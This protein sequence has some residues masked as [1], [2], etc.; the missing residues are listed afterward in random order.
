MS[1]CLLAAHLQ[2][3]VKFFALFFI[4]FLSLLGYHDNQLS[5]PHIVPGLLNYYMHISLTFNIG[6]FHALRRN[7]IV[8]KKI[9]D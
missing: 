5:N 1:F 3:V 7:Y 6:F 2:S 8:L 4:P 9:R